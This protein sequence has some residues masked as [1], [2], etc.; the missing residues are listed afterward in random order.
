VEAA[1]RQGVGSALLAEIERQMARENVRLVELETAT[2]NRPAIA[3]WK[4]HG[5]RPVSVY[6]RYYPGGAD[7]YRMVKQLALT[8]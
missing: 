5:Y 4:K 8:Q 2:N 1:R 3:F 7:A 6:R